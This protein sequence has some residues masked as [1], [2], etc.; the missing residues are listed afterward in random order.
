MARF[1]IDESQWNNVSD[2]DKDQIIQSLKKN[3]L[4]VEG[5]SIVGVP[6]DGSKRMWHPPALHID[7][8][9]CK[10]GCD[11]LA[12]AAAASLT[13]TGPGL[14]VALALIEV[15]RQACRDAC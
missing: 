7:N 6:S 13:V 9:F 5:D 14:A 4:M 10:I 3:R 11:A 12:A 2:S 8:Q 1:E 15:A